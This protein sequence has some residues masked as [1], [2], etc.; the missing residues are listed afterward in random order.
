MSCSRS[1]PTSSCSGLS[2]A[3]SKTPA[4]GA[5]ASAMVPSADRAVAVSATSWTAANGARV[6]SA[7][8]R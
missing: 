7:T 3:G 6:D 8:R 1:T 5:S 4:R 2:S